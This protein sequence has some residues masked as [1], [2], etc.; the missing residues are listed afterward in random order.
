MALKPDRMYQPMEDISRFWPTGSITE[1]NSKAGGIVSLVASNSGVGLDSDG[2][3]GVD[4]GHSGND[5]TVNYAAQASGALPVGLL[6]QDIRN[7][8]TSE[9]RRRNLH[10]NVAY[11]GGKVHLIRKGWVV[12]DRIVGTPTAGGVAY[13]HHSGYI[14]VVPAQGSASPTIVGKF[15]TIKDENGF[16]RVFVDL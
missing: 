8:Q 11:V 4:P 2:S 12:T 13:L 10:A 3:G 6:T 7:D 16:A 15:E 5:N 14:G 1:A 9:P